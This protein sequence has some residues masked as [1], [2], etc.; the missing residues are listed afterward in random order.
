MV[1]TIYL[2][3]CLPETLPSLAA[4]SSPSSTTPQVGNGKASSRTTQKADTTT[5]PLRRTN[6]HFLLNLTHFTFILFFSGLEFS[7][8]FMTHD[9]FSLSPS[10]NGKLL[11][12][13]GL[14]ASLLQGG[15][16]RRIPPLLS[17]KLGV[18]SC[19]GAFLLLGRISS[20]GGLYGAASLLA[21]TTA[22]V[23]TGLNALSSFEAGVGERGEKLGNLRSWGQAG[24]ATGPLAF[25]TLYWW[26]GREV[27]YG[28]GAAGMLT[29]TGLVFGALKTPRVE[30]HE[31]ATSKMAKEI[32]KE[33]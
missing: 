3:F 17:I 22:T 1:E 30:G 7:L 27:A 5:R 10:S 14:I 20:V 4:P 11:G 8:P 9:L 24:R 21:V 18:I 13:I 23:V 6:S 32:K 12:F 29:V 15:V 2:Y 25:C 19:L 16:T 28:L 33:L 31:V 26:A